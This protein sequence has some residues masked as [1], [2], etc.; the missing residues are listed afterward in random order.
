MMAFPWNE[1]TTSG[2]AAA[3]GTETPAFELK[4]KLHSSAPRLYDFNSYS[5]TS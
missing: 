4:Q 1:Q 3:K 2:E 5:T